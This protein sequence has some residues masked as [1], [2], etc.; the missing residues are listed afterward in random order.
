MSNL[1][2]QVNEGFCA[3]LC[4]DVD[5]ICATGSIDELHGM[6]MNAVKHLYGIYEVNLERVFDMQK[7]ALD[8]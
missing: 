2:Y 6:Y 8:E 5:R 3:A 7:G 4:D 1:K